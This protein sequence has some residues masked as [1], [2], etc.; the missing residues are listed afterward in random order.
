M[1][2]S[3]IIIIGEESEIKDILEKFQEKS[4]LN[5]IFKLPIQ[6]LTYF[7]DSERCSTT[8]KSE[9]QPKKSKE[10]VRTKIHILHRPNKGDNNQCT[11]DNS[12]DYFGDV[13]EKKSDEFYQLLSNSL[14]NKVNILLK[15]SSSSSLS[16]QGEPEVC[17]SDH[18]ENIEKD[19]V[20]QSV[21][22]SKN[23]LLLIHF[24][25]D[26]NNIHGD[27]LI[28]PI[29]SPVNHK[30]LYKYE[31]TFHQYIDPLDKEEI[32][33]ISNK[34]IGFF[35]IVHLR[36]S[37]KT[38]CCIIYIKVPND[39]DETSETLI[40]K[41]FNEVTDEIFL[42]QYESLNTPIIL[43]ENFTLMIASLFC[44]CNLIVTILIEDSI[45][46]DRM[47]CYY[48][49][50]LPTSVL[51]EEQNTSDSDEP[52]VKVNSRRKRLIRKCSKDKK[53]GCA[54]CGKKYFETGN[55][56]VDGV[57]KFS[58]IHKSL[59]TYQKYRTIKITYE[60]PGG[61]QNI[62]HPSPGSWYDGIKK[63]AYLPNNEE[64]KELLK[65]L[66]I[67]FK[68]RLIFT[69]KKADNFE[70]EDYVTWNDIVHKTE[71]EPGKDTKEYPNDE[72]LLNLRT[73]LNSKGIK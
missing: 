56:P 66:K 42:E 53:P 43:S 10:I 24:F 71:I 57:M 16:S 12:F 11:I 34:D 55:Q 17:S 19:Y 23:E 21:L 3:N 6:S 27:I 47:K 35:K 28:I 8:L 18:P 25:Q 72:Y 70:D 26:S 1:H 58:K 64:G 59:P 15:S 7:L 22:A 31:K 44:Q 73:V 4:H 65:L 52:F 41:A 68:R 33:A 62:E 60:I 48:K 49:V 67:A 9:Q 38:A 13:N 14:E 20:I 54:I 30:Q 32:N 50:K 36:E 46:Y 37:I 69:I 2:Y 39:Q 40:F 63:V 5:G 61:I 51:D 45:I 29:C